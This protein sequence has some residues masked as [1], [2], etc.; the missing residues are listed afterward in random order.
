MAFWQICALLAYCAIVAF[1]GV[2]GFHRYQLLRLFYRYH[3]ERLPEPELFAE[4]PVITVQLPLYNEYHVVDR[5]LDAVGALDYPR[6]RFEIQVLDDSQDE[7]R[8]RARAAPSRRR[9][10]RRAASPRGSA[11]APCA[12][13]GQ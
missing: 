6:E 9:N 5:L 3:P 4:L 8:A 1:L 2:Y 13:P 12:A 11:A 10:C 7:T